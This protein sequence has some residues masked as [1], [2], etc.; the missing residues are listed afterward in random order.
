MRFPDYGDERSPRN[1]IRSR[2]SPRTTSSPV[3]EANPD[4]LEPER[5]PPSW[6]RVANHARAM[7]A[8]IVAQAI[9]SGA[10]LVRDVGVPPRHALIDLTGSFD[11][12]HM[13][14]PDEAVA[15]V[16]HLGA[17]VRGRCVWWRTSRF[18]SLGRAAHDRQIETRECRIARSVSRGRS[19]DTSKGQVELRMPPVLWRLGHVGDVQRQVVNRARLR[20]QVLDDSVAQRGSPTRTASKRARPLPRRPERTA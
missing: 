10:R 17:A 15:R 20:S 18:L 4:A 8:P 16:S 1:L 7:H 11:K 3:R 5:P 6:C 19:C 2:A 12:R 13:V 14:R 9:P